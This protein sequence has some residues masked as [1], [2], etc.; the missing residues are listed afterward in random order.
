MF[1]ISS[2][3]DANDISADC[4]DGVR[5]TGWREGSYLFAKKPATRKLIA[6]IGAYLTGKTE[7]EL[8][9][10]QDGLLH[11]GTMARIVYIL[12]A[13]GFA[14]QASRIEE[15]MDEICSLWEARDRLRKR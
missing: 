6:R 14:S 7:A 12:R 10:E 9:P 5:H 1:E 13:N 4:I 3:S 8:P 2:K 15:A 11:P